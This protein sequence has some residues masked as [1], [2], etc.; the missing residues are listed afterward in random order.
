MLLLGDNRGGD[1]GGGG[2]KDRRLPPSRHAEGSLQESKCM[3]LK[4]R[5]SLNIVLEKSGSGAM[6]V[7]R[8]LFRAR[9]FLSV[10]WIGILGFIAYTEIPRQIASPIWGYVHWVRKELD[11]NKLDPKLRELPVAV[12]G[13]IEG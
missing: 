6:N 13:K 2:A 9:I 3:T 10:L 5:T 8:G 11:M 7:G 12:S 1:S 4:E